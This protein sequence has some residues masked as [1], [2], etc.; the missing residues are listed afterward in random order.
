M[1]KLVAIVLFACALSSPALAQDR[2]TEPVTEIDFI[3][4]DQ[5]TGERASAYIDLIGARRRNVRETLIRARTSFRPEL[6]KTVED[7]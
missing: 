7:I 4:A 1:K 5:V 6:V 3:D 2:R